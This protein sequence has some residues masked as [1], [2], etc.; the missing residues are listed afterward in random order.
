MKFIA[1]QLV[2]KKIVITETKVMTRKGELTEKFRVFGR[3]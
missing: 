2:N 3:R 1:N